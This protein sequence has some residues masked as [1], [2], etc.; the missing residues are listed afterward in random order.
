MNTGR[1]RDP[2]TGMFVARCPIYPKHPAPCH[3]PIAS[4][5][6]CLWPGALRDDE[7]GPYFDA[8]EKPWSDREARNVVFGKVEGIYFAGYPNSKQKGYAVRR[9]PSNHEDRPVLSGVNRR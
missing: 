9:G 4:H 6:V 3:E 1:L 5:Y 8:T 2:K 7:I